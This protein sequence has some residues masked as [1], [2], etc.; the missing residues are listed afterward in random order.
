MRCWPTG[1]CWRTDL[2]RRA[3]A[4][5]NTV[6]AGAVGTMNADVVYR[7]KLAHS[8]RPWQGVNA[9]Y[10]A[11]AALGRFAARKEEPVV[12]EGLEFHDTITVTLAARRRHPQRRARRVPAG[13]Q[14]ARR[15][16]P[17]RSPNARA[18]V[19]ALAAPGAVEWLDESPSAVPNITQPAVRAFIEATGVEVHPKQAWTDVATLQAAGIPALN[20]GPGEASQAHQR[21]EW[22]SIAALEHCEQVLAD[23]LAALMRAERWQGAGNV[24]LL[25]EEAPADVAA[26]C[27]DHEA[28][29]VL[30]LTAVAG[31]DVA[32]R[33]INPDGSEPEACGNGTRMVA[34]VRG[35]ARRA[36]TRCGSTTGAGVLGD[37]HPRRRHR[38]GAH[39]RRAADRRRPVPADRRA[40]S[41]P[42]PVR[43]GRQPA[44]GDPGRRPRRLPARLPGPLPRAP[45]VVS[46]A[47]QHRGVAAARRRLGRDA[48][49]GARRGRDAGVRHRRRAPS[50]SPPCSTAWRTA[51]SGCT[52]RAVRSRSQSARVSR[53]A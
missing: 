28:D 42:A 26:L 7:G 6:H 14:R 21:D 5:G 44:R 51:R 16:R 31:A 11:A 9:I 19:E 30:V 13:R 10:E 33:I 24:Y 50:P 41:L 35:G 18:E 47:R 46:A 48:R 37:R 34:A 40:V 4:D 36:R 8:A 43:V 12:V 53:S 23:Y 38:H 20:Y 32:M 15:T 3:R 29:G 25:V 2:R 39:G 17:R 22:V 1:A 27:R 45:R 52:C 49:V